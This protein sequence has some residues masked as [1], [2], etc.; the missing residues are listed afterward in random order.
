MFQLEIRNL[1]LSHENFHPNNPN[2]LS[3]ICTLSTSSTDTTTNESSVDHSSHHNGTT[4]HEKIVLEIAAEQMR[5]YAQKKYVKNNIQLKN[6]KNKHFMHYVRDANKISTVGSHDNGNG[7]DLNNDDQVTDLVLSFVRNFVNKICDESGVN[8]TH[9]NSL[10]TKLY[11][12]EKVYHETRKVASI[13]KPLLSR[14]VII[15]ELSEQEESIAFHSYLLPDGRNE[16]FIGQNSLLLAEG[17]LIMTN[18]RLI[19][20]VCPVNLKGLIPPKDLSTH[21]TMSL[22]S[23]GTNSTGFLNTLNGSTRHQ[24]NILIRTLEPVRRSLTLANTR[25]PKSLS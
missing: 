21:Q 4:I 8:I 10:H 7:F 16:F 24:P 3:I 19:F 5:L 12:I 1:Y 15:S 9:E 13:P 22:K 11:L 14:F 17:A 23:N 2:T 25:S 6:L 20:K 18:Y